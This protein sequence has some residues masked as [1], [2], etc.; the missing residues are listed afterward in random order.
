MKKIL[1]IEDNEAIRE[2]IAEIL[3]IAGYEVF[4]A[5]N[6]KTGVDIALKNIPDLVLCDIMMPVLDGYGTLHIFQK[7]TNLSN[8]PFIFL[9]AKTERADLRKAMEMGADDYIP[10]PFTELELLSAI[11]NRWRKQQNQQSSQQRVESFKQFWQEAKAHKELKTLSDNRKVFKYKKKQIIYSQGSEPLK[12]YFL[13]KGRVKIYKIHPDGKE[14]ITEICTEGDFF[15]YNAL[16]ENTNYVESA[17]FLEDSEVIAIPKDEFMDLLF[18]NQ[19]ISFQFIKMLANNITEKEKFL[20]NTTYN[21]LRKRVAE[22]LAN[23]APKFD[24]GKG[25]IKLE[26]SRED[27]ASLVGTATESLIRTLSDFKEEKLID[28]IKGK[29]I[30]RDLNKVKN[31]KY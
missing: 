9:T 16:I 28:I 5:E 30:I 12:L 23:I 24:T 10:K 3:E 13:Q 18:K 20:L 25:E 7:N 27:L 2:N 21:S 8:I 26:I 31:L 15:G 14:L 22:T 6:G 4:T 17:E 29:I 1:V 11:E 19:N